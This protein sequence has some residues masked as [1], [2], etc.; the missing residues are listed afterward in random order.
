MHA[1]STTRRTWTIESFPGRAR[2]GLS[3]LSQNRATRLFERTVLWLAVLILALTPADGKAADQ[4]PGGSASKP[5]RKAA[6]PGRSDP[7]TQPAVENVPATLDQALAKALDNHPDILAAKAKLTLAEAELNRTRMDV[8][9]KIIG[10]WN[11]R[12]AQKEKAEINRVLQANNAMSMEDVIAARA[13]LAQSETELRYLIGQI[14]PPGVRSHGFATTRRPPRGPIVDKVR[15]TLNAPTQ[16]NFTDEKLNNILDYLADLHRID[17][18]LDSKAFEGKGFAID[19]EKI[20]LNVKGV[21]LASGLQALEDQHPPLKF[22][23]RDY[24]ILATT[25]SRAEEEGFFPAAEF[26]DL[27][28]GGEA[29][30]PVRLSDPGRASGGSPAKKPEKRPQPSTGPR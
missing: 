25:S 12:Q 10:L 19:K 8:A 17:F 11:E 24:G 3:E 18:Q 20:G 29:T 26:A 16:I 22:V 27:S 23:V 15:E 9:R 2:L 30:M 1:L 14:V 4:P 6:S 13:S 5:A 21:P 7:G 28:G